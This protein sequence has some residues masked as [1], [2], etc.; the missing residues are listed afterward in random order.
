M[1][2]FSEKE[3]DVIGFAKSIMTEIEGI[4]SFEK[5]TDKETGTGFQLPTESRLNAFLRLI[6]LPYFVVIT[7][8]DGNEQDDLKFLNPGFGA[9]VR[10]TLADKKISDSYRQEYTGLDGKSDKVFYILSNRSELLKEISEEIGSDDM[11]DRMSK[12]I[13]APLD[14]KPNTPK[15]LKGVGTFIP[16][17]PP[18]GGADT[19]NQREVFKKLLP[20]I[21]SYQRVLPLRNE[22]ARPFTLKIRERRIDRNTILRKPFIEQ[23]VRTRFIVYGSSQTE[24]EKVL[25]EDVTTTIKGLLGEQVFSEV[26][27]NGELFAKVN[28]LEE[29]VISKFLDAIRNLARR[30][31]KINEQRIRLLRTLRPTIAIKTSSARES[32]FGKRVEVSAT[33]EGTSDGEKLKKINAAIAQ[34]EALIA[35]LPTDENEEAEAKQQGTKNITPSAL[36]NSF[37]NLLNYNLKRNKETKAALISRSKKN[38]NSL[39]KLRLEL[40]LM[41]GEFSGLSLPDVV[42]TIAALFMVK[43]DILLN[44]LDK[45]TIDYMKTDKVLATIASQAG[46][47]TPTKAMAAVKALEAVVNQLFTL[48]Q[49]EVEA[50]QN[51]KKQGRKAKSIRKSD[52]KAPSEPVCIPAKETS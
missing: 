28:L 45:Y 52:A 43:R 31:V 36:Q 21:P 3:F 49:T 27:T 38:I 47:P 42:I 24:K 33:L 46:D 5:V 39:E 1:T 12:A 8:K 51:R 19:Q 34:E 48:F 11:N 7:D 29:F 37:T 22:I 9:T 50:V 17:I 40:D 41:T 25:G 26:F 35:L 15:A 16:K 32:L 4:R 13:C 23:V 14:I 30:W 20:L 2:E 44:L 18:K 6:G 10:S